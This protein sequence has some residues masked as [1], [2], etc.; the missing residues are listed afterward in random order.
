MLIDTMTLIAVD[1]LWVVEASHWANVKF[2]Q[3]HIEWSTELRLPCWKGK[4]S[5]GPNLFFRCGS[6]LTFL[7]NLSECKYTKKSWHGLQLNS[8]I[9][10]S[11]DIWN[12]CSERKLPKYNVIKQFKPIQIKV[13]RKKNKTFSARLRSW[14]FLVIAQL[15]SSPWSLYSEEENKIIWCNTGKNKCF[16]DYALVKK[17]L[18]AEVNRYKY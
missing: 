13:P 3:I 15:S 5:H 4:S 12:Q 10:K 8:L 11:D 7:K 1:L 17:T 16:G 2:P 9:I 14:Q 6:V 18:Y